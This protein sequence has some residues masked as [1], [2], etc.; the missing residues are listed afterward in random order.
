MSR[1]NNHV[2]SSDSESD[3]YEEVLTRNTAADSEI[4]ETSQDLTQ[5]QRDDYC[6]EDNE[7]QIGQY[8]KVR[9][10]MDVLVG[11]LLSRWWYV[12]PDWPPANYNYREQLEKHMLKCYP[13]PEFED[14]ENVDSNGYTKC[15]QLSAFPGV[16]RDFKGIAHDL[17]PI[18]GKPC[19]NNLI[20]KPREELIRLIKAAIKKQIELLSKSPYD[21]SAYIERLQEELSELK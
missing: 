7:I 12:L 3:D 20:Q 14:H 19:Y 18:E 4:D 5:S 16:F 1:Y 11:K 8:S 9:T 6:R 15:Y 2:V 17:R 21:E 13:V 10:E